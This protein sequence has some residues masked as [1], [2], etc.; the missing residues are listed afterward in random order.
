VTPAE[1]PESA[2]SEAR[3]AVARWTRRIGL[4]AAETGS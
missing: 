3:E 4:R 2:G 1:G